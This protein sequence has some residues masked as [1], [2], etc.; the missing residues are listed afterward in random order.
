M[1][2]IQCELVADSGLDPSSEY[3]R[4]FFAD[5]GPLWHA[6]IPYT[7]IPTGGDSPAWTVGQIIP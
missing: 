4:T 6:L 7:N 3:T 5:I 1:A 2:T